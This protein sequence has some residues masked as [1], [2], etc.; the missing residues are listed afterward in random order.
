MKTIDWR[1]ATPEQINLWNVASA[2]IAFNTITPIYFM[3]AIAAS[4]FLIYNAG[5]IYIALEVEFS[6]NSATSAAPPVG[7]IVAY[8]SMDIARTHFSNVLPAWDT[9][10]AAMEYCTMNY[11]KKNIYFSRI[12]ATLYTSMI[13]NGYRLNV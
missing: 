4:E 11:F 13:F 2:L 10:A 12:A 6:Y 1:N 7:Q 5:K 8:D 3:G 9:T